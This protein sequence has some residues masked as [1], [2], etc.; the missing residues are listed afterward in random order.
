MDKIWDRNPLKSEIIGSWGGDKKTNDH[1][2]PKKS[3][4]NLI[5]STCIALKNNFISLV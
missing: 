2:E 1:A 5:C 3:N 4:L